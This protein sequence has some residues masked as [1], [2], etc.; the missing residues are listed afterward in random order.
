MA[1]K[2]LSADP[3]IK[4]F[5]VGKRS[6]GTTQS[7]TL[8]VSAPTHVGEVYSLEVNG[9]ECSYTSLMSDTSTIV[10]TALELL[11][12]AV[13]DVSSSSAVNVI[14]VVNT[15]GA[16][17][18]NS[19]ASWTRNIKI[20]DASTDPGIA[21]DLAALYAADTD[22]YGLC[23][24]SN[25]R[26]E[27][28][29]A[30]AW[31]EANKRVFSC[32]TSDSEAKDNAVTTDVASSLKAAAY[33]RTHLLFN[34]KK[35]DDYSGC[36]TLGA[37][38]V[39][40]PGSVTWAYKTLAGVTADDKD[41]VRDGEFTALQFKRCNVYQT[42]AGINTTFEG[43]SPAGEY[44]DTVHFIDWLT[45]E[46]QIALFALLISNKKVP[47]T[48]AGVDQVK[49]VVFAVL[50]AG[51]DAGGLDSPPKITEIT[52]PKVANVS[53]LDKAA[54]HLPN[55]KFKKTLAGAIHKLTVS[56]TLSV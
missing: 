10:A 15:N 56:G 34:G 14:T 4:D 17:Y 47:F 6:T 2:A 45:S 37:V 52:A 50:Q 33:T 55:V 48:D 31:T 35:T 8:T 49:N 19:F 41:S 25:S 7:F 24:D 21:A 26:A 46:M 40:D 22:W 42:F 28:L 20:K 32:N 27:I 54:R 1:A 44:L 12:E 29:A 38:F 23:V 53:T 11:I 30:A 13:T 5:K 18:L 3:T 43:I 51:F 39:D 36:A 9:V 16:G